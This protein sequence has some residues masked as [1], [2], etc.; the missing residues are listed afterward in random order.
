MPERVISRAVL[1][2]IALVSPVEEC[3]LEP[4]KFR[5]AVGEEVKID[6]LTGENFVGERWDGKENKAALVQWFSASGMKDLSKE[7]KAEP[8]NQLKVKGQQEGTQM[9]V[10][11]T[12]TLTRDWEADKFKAYLEDNGLDDL[13]TA[14]RNATGP[15]VPARHAD[16]WYAT[17]VAQTGALTADTYKQ[18]VGRR[19]E[20]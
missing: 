4:D 18:R 5:Y 12:N 16:I 19:L 10:M 14:G 6:F 17:P 11:E 8:G 9:V 13:A 1:L 3:W 2:A 7:A 15:Q 20:M